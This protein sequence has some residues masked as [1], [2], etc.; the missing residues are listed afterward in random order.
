MKLKE[1]NSVAIKNINNVS[2]SNNISSGE[3]NYKYFI[4]YLYDDYKIEPLYIMLSKTSAYVKSYDC[5]TK[6]MYFLNE[7]DNLLRKYNA[8]CVKVSTD[9]KKEFDS[10]P[11]YN[12]IFLKTT[13][14]LQ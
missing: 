1:I 11:V 7:D 8:I 14:K 10:E 4:G 3:K 2:V 12:K 6:W 5:Q 9:I 13:I